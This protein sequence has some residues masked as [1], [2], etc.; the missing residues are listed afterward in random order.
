MAGLDA[1]E[2]TVSARLRGPGHFV[3]DALERPFTVLSGSGR[4]LEVRVFD[5]CRIDDI[6]SLT[7]RLIREARAL[8][9]P[10]IIFGDFR[11][12]PPFSQAV[13]DGWSRDMRGFNDKVARSAFLLSPEN[14]TFNLQFARVVRCAGSAYRRWF[15]DSGELREWLRAFL[16]D[17]EL[18]RVDQLMCPAVFARAF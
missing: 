1:L 9:G 15:C 2:G 18:G 14:E 10:P 8:A 11:A 12:A 5:V 3:P 17:V 6:A 13:A 16:T 4:L 7:A